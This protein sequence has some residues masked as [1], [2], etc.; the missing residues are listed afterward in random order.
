VAVTGEAESA[1]WLLSRA[2]L[3]GYAAKDL[4]RNRVYVDRA[5]D[6]ELV[7][8]QLEMSRLSDLL[9]GLEEGR[10]ELAFQPLVRLRGTSRL[11]KRGELLL[12]WRNDQDELVSAGA[13]IPA[14]ERYGLMAT[15]D[16]WVLRE[17]LTFFG[18]R[19]PR[20]EGLDGIGLNLSSN[21]LADDAFAERVK[22][23]LADTGM[24]PDR[25][26]FEITETAAVNNLEQALALIGRLRA[27]GCRFALDDFGSGLSSF[28]LLR[29]LPIDMLK[30]DGSFVRRMVEDGVD[31]AVV[32]ATTRVARAMGIAT[33]AEWVEQVDLL[34]R[35]RALGI[36]Y[37]QGFA[38]G[39]PV[40]LATL[41]APAARAARRPALRGGVAQTSASRPR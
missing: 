34:P 23:A 3:A 40:P 37:A 13:F 20:G 32:E 15:L 1:A 7:R 9:A 36:D 25:L 16:S 30:V 38:V 33:V 41:A 28:R 26:W 11:G 12:R 19:F 27:L 35:L 39:A 5:G 24:P 2:D 31:A 22:Q 18:R 17:A 14:A 29:S 8:R 10:F 6:P 21:T 4:G